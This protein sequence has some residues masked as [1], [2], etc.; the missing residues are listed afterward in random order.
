MTVLAALRIEGIP[1]LISDFLITDT[2]PR[3]HVLLPTRLHNLPDATLPRRINGTQR[4]C[5]LINNRLIV[6]FTG[7]V[8]A[9]KRIFSELEN[10]FGG[11]DYGP[12]TEELD[13][14]LR[15]LRIPLHNTRMGGRPISGQ[16]VG[17]TMRSRP[18]C[19]AWSSALGAPQVRRV[20]YAIEGSGKADFTR[21]LTSA[22]GFGYSP[23]VQTAYDKAVLLGITKIGNVLAHEV[24]SGDNLA[25]GYGGGA[26]IALFTGDRFEFVPKIG[27][28]FFHVRLELNGSVS[29]AQAGVMASYEN[30]GRYALLTVMQSRHVERGM[31][32]VENAYCAALTPIHDDNDVDIL[33]S[34]LVPNERGWALTDPSNIAGGPPDMV[35]PYYFFGFSILDVKSGVTRLATGACKMSDD[36]AILQV[37]RD[38]GRVYFTLLWSEIENLARQTFSLEVETYLAKFH[39]DGTNWRHRQ[40]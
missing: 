31:L 17:W 25:L 40:T 27:Y 4:K 16:I 5:V 33:K 11:R 21:S 38:G 6:G 34:R 12:T 35:C 36:L 30:R 32:K 37:R 7:D 23:A 20:D 3:P 14:V 24:I 1:A 15:L 28:L 26:E 13:R 9:G 29:F 22:V 19:F 2:Q 18:C 10:K 8:P 39:F